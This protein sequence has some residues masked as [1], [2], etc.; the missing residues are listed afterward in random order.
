MNNALD[1]GMNSPGSSPGWGHTH[2]V[3]FLDKH[4]I[5]T[6]SVLGAQMG[7]ST[8]LV[9]TLPFSTM[10]LLYILIYTLSLNLFLV[11][12]SLNRFASDFPLS[13]M[14]YHYLTKI[15]FY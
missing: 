1:S 11:R 13:H 5:L 14:H 7:T 15:F 6:V 2:C 3:V 12:N 4:F 9:K 10:M 8:R